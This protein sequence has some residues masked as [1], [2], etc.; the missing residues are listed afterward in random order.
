MRKLLLSILISAIL[1]MLPWA[2]ISFSVWDRVYRD[3]DTVPYREVGVLLGTTPWANGSN[4]FFTTRIEATKELY[5]RWKIKKIIV[6]GDN[7]NASYNEPEYMKRALIKSGVPENVITMDYAWFRTLDSVV[8]A[9]E[10]FS[11]TLG[12]TIISQPFHIE[13]AIFLAKANGIDAIGYG[14]ANVSLE[15]GLYAYL[16]EVPARWLALYDAW[17]G[18]EATVLGEKEEIGN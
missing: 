7:S 3:I 1:L 4:L 6:S 2:I 14:A 13:R 8:R 16:R 18:T 12:F 5:E 11:L 17:F 10:V 15:Y 9:S